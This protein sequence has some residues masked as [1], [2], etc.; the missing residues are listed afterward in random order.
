M[1][2]LSAQGLNGL[3]EDRRAGE[4]MSFVETEA[5]EN[6]VIFGGVILANVLLALLMRFVFWLTSP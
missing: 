4:A 2:T 1:Y 5:Q 3:D 6:V